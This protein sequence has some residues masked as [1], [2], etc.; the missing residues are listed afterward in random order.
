MDET[1]KKL[2]EAANILEN[3]KALHQAKKVLVKTQGLDDV[4]SLIDEKLSLCNKAVGFDLE[5]RYIEADL[6]NERID[7]ILKCVS[8]GISA[9]I[10]VT[11]IWLLLS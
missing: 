4:I 8:I 9:F 2:C 1:I 3:A 10:I 6:E 5:Q 11:S 7:R